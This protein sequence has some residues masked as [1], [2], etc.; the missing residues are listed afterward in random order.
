MAVIPNEVSSLILQRRCRSYYW[1]S[2]C[3]V[4]LDHLDQTRTTVEPLSRVIHLQ[5]H[6]GI[7]YLGPST[8]T[9][10]ADVNLITRRRNGF[11]QSSFVQRYEK[12]VCIFLFIL[13]VLKKGRRK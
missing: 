12:L 8:V 10:A 4:V 2:Y 9:G 11:F 13:R 7:F 3:V 5:D 1:S 6:I